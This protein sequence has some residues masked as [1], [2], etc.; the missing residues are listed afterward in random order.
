MYRALG[1]RVVR[2]WPL[3]IGGWVVLLIALKI[4]APPWLDVVESGEFAFLPEESPSLQGEAVYR[5]AWGTDYASNIVVVVRRD[6]MQLEERDREFI[7]TVLKDEL[8]KIIDEVGIPEPA[9][10]VA[11]ADD[12]PSEPE[13]VEPAADDSE[14]EVDPLEVARQ[15][16]KTFGSFGWEKILDSSDGTA[17]MVVIDLKTEFLNQDNMPLIDRVEELIRRGSGKSLYDRKVKTEDGEEEPVVPP[18]LN[19]ALSGSATVGRDMMEAAV[20]SSK[21]T[22]LWT[23]ILVV[24]LLIMIYRAPVLAMIPLLTVFIATETSLALL[25]ILAEHGILSLFNGAEVYIKVLSYGAGVDYCLFLIARFKEELDETKDPA[26]AV[27]GSIEKVG[28]A[29]VASAG[30][31]ICGIGMMM[32]ADFGKFAQAGTTIPIALIVVL[33]ASLTFTPAILRMTGQWAFWPH[34]STQRL[35]AT[36]GWV[37]ST[38]FFAW[39]LR[40]NVFETIWRK[41]SELIEEKPAFVL[42]LSVALMLPFSVIAVLFFNNLSYGLLSELPQENASVIGARAIQSHYPAG[43]AGPVTL[44]LHNPKIDFTDEQTKEGLNQVVE[45]LY[46]RRDE[47]RLADIR[48]VV[49]PFGIASRDSEDPVEAASE[50]PTEAEDGP[51]AGGGIFNA[52]LGGRNDEDEG[53]QGGGFADRLIAIAEARKAQEFY[54][55]QHGDYE[56]TMTRIDLVSVD[57]PFSRGSINQF[58]QLR[59][60]VLETANKFLVGAGEAGSVEVF[61]VG[62]TASIRDLKTVTDRDQR[63][64]D[65]LVLGGIFAILLVLLRGFANHITVSIY[66]I[67]SV[68]FSYL[69]TL[70]ATFAFFWAIDPSGFTGL[71][72]KVP[73]FLFTIL[74]AVG[75]D[76]NIF[77]MTRIREEQEQHGRIKG[78]GVALTKTGGIISSCGIIMAGT[79]SSLLA[80]TLAGMQQ[81]GFALA[82]GVLLDTFVVRPILVP[83]FLVLLYQGRFDWLRTLLHLPAIGADTDEP[84]RGDVDD[85]QATAGEPAPAP[86]ETGGNA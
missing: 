24:A 68:F 22:E 30:T 51:V 78:V 21:A 6:K 36:A 67:V 42:S 72:W 65:A 80:G 84:P 19:L 73:T 70:G 49:D 40:K 5:E 13:T 44:L 37:S 85:R 56:G 11:V 15:K 17:T 8:A 62:S 66:L 23:T 3:M 54:V 52:I 71:D 47:L 12:S 25:S 76:Y 77:L 86:V 50:E 53:N 45:S 83:A 61:A 2:H 31:V 33:V 46:G 63:V 41:T 14:P 26:T 32:F 55:G 4:A 27:S 34:V 75:E 1:K 79:F 18:G 69:V 10:T 29:L 38:G 82:F 7:Q 20:E 57:D 9:R 28:E 59:A 48:S 74:I 64:V 16:I 58:T 60:E 81:L 35:Q 43:T 39:L